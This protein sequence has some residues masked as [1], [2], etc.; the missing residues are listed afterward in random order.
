MIKNVSDE[1]LIGASI[2]LMLVLKKEMEISDAIYQQC[3]NYW[4]G[5]HAF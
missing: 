5:M 3:F 2:I 4:C 1:Y